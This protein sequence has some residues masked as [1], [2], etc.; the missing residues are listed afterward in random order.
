MSEFTV[1]FMIAFA[2]LFIIFF[3]LVFLYISVSIGKDQKQLIKDLN[4]KID[5]IKNENK[6]LT[7]KV[8]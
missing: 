6:L 3:L 1:S 2:S 8:M 7:N 5:L 4:Y